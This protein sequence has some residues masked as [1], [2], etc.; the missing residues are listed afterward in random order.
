MEDTQEDLSTLNDHL[1]DVKDNIQ[2]ITYSETE[3]K[4]S[5][6]EKVKKY[7]EVIPLLKNESK[8]K[9]SKLNQINQKISAKTKVSKSKEQEEELEKL[10]QIETTLIKRISDENKIL[11]TAGKDSEQLVLLQSE[12]ARLKSDNLMLQ[13]VHKETKLAAVQSSEDINDDEDFNDS[14]NKALDGPQNIL[15]YTSL[16]DVANKVMKGY[17]E[18]CELTQARNFYKEVI[19]DEGKYK[20]DQKITE[21]LVHDTIRKLKNYETEYQAK[22]TDF[23]NEYT[24]VEIKNQALKSDQQVFENDLYVETAKNKSNSGEFVGGGDFFVSFC[25]VMSVLLCFFVVFFAI[26]DQSAESFD[27]F[28][29]TWPYK[30]PNKK[31]IR[32]NNV[33]LS[34]QELKL[35]DKA[36]E[37]VE[38]GIS[39]EAITRSDTKVIEL[40]ESNIDLFVPGKINI[41]SSGSNILK[42]KLKNILSKGGI[43]QIRVEGHTN[44]D[45]FNRYPKLKNKYSNNLAFSIARA[46]SVAQIIIKNFKFPENQTIITGYGAKQPVKFSSS[47]SNNKINSRIEIKILQ[48]KNIKNSSN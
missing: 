12:T 36:K 6:D 33:S 28:F 16:V 38:L 43:R 9:E 47:S 34:K 45:E 4:I 41:S 8:R 27:R 7:K 48:D 46:S 44:D 37:L 30:N 29:A 24:D 5:F 40:I 32:P 23:I 18:G 25:D 2:E 39:P 26:S 19:G 21:T 31:I 11:K 3:K 17:Y 22:L 1:Q 42:K 15:K 14:S 20:L 35:I 10:Y 13:K